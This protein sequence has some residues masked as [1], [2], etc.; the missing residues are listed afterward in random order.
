M[1]KNMGTVDRVSRLFLALVI[2]VLYF[3]GTIGGTLGLVLAIVAAVFLLT[4]F[5]GRCPAYIPFGLS[6]CKQPK[7][8]SQAA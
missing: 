1:T 7:G 6:T 8:P 4:S 3:T 5:A 2:A